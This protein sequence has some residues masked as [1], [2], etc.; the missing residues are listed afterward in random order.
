LNDWTGR[1]FRNGTLTRVRTGRPGAKEHDAVVSPA[2]IW[3]KRKCNQAS[4]TVCGS[5][6]A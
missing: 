5:L 4:T 1:M 2:A 3:T 6:G